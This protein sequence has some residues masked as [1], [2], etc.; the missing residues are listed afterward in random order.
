MGDEANTSSSSQLDLFS[1]LE[2]EGILD[3]WNNTMSTNELE[4]VLQAALEEAEKDQA[5]S[6]NA[7]KSKPKKSQRGK[8]TEESEQSTEEK[9]SQLE[10]QVSDLQKKLEKIQ[11]SR[12]DQINNF[13]S[14]M[15]KEKSK[16]D[17]AMKEVI[18]NIQNSRNENDFQKQLDEI[19]DQLEIKQGENYSLQD[20]IKKLNSTLNEGQEEVE[21]HMR[22]K[23]HYKIELDEMTANVERLKEEKNTD[24]IEIERLTALLGQARQENEFLSEQRFS[25]RSQK[26]QVEQTKPVEALRWA[27]SN[28][29]NIRDHLEKTEGIHWSSVRDIFLTKKIREK[30][31]LQ[32]NK[33]KMEDADVHVVM[34]GYNE[35]KGGMEAEKIAKYYESDIKPIIDTRKPVLLVEVPPV[36]TNV[37]EKYEARDLNKYIKTISDRYENVSMVHTWEALKEVHP[38][39]I[40]KRDGYHYDPSK[41]G[42]EVVAEEI[43]KAV[44]RATTKNTNNKSTREI[45]IR[46]GT[47]AYFIGKGGDRVKEMQRNFHVDIQ[48]PENESKIIVI[49]EQRRLNPAEDAIRK[50]LDDF[51]SERQRRSQVTCT[52]Y[53]RGSCRYGD[54]CHFKHSTPTTSREREYHNHRR[55]QRPRSRSDVRRPSDRWVPA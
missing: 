45:R 43:N 27:N 10:T 3:P 2:T 36:Q 29:G 6:K 52:N 55:E 48:F 1:Q 46:P 50:I 16:A 19:K 9:N 25:Q 53:S 44:K 22:E 32:E 18:T 41:K 23:L 14:L 30:A 38:E 40:F 20:Q 42:S 31:K 51:E 7:A 15:R 21:K 5:E 28:G 47:A 37:N 34:M 26:Q 39:Q 17:A 54:A 4:Q 12:Q 24:K 33:T 35:I 49:G 11:K 13:R 8:E